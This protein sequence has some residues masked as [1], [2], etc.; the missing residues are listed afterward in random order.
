MFLLRLQMNGLRVLAEIPGLLDYLP[1]YLL[2]EFHF[3]SVIPE[4]EA[5][6]GITHSPK[7]LREEHGERL[8]TFGIRRNVLQRKI[9]EFAEKSGVEFKWSHHL[10]SL[11]QNENSVTGIFA[12]G[13]KETFSFVVGCDGLHSNTRVSLFGQQPAEYT[14]MSQVRYNVSIIVEYHLQMVFFACSTEDTHQ[15]LSTSRANLSA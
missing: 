5:V 15:L 10:E 1:R 9:V 2:D 7:T 6:L 8:G 13:V 14:G 3:Y 12:N 4:D 11:E